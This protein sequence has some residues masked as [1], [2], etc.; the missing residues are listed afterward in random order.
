MQSYINKCSAVS[1]IEYIFVY[2]LRYTHKPLT[3]KL[4]YEK[5]FTLEVNDNQ[6][7]R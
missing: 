6:R 1:V 5:N 4:N 7:L 2:S 3:N